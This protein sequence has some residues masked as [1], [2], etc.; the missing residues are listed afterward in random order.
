MKRLTLVRH[1]KSS[2]KDRALADV[3]RPLKKRGKRDAPDMGERLAK[4]KVKPDRIVS[5][6]AQR[7]LDTARLLAGEVGYP[8]EDIVVDQGAYTFDAPALLRVIEGL[9]D[10]VEHV[11][12]VAHNPALTDVVNAVADL[13]LENV[14][15]C[16]IVDLEFSADTWAAVPSAHATLLHYD[17]PK[18]PRK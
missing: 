8:T 10:T 1:A 13:E 15:T 9:D 12:L 14:P 16:G 2:R 4:R 11:M 3:D 17:Y 7:A 6:P 5:S 18:K